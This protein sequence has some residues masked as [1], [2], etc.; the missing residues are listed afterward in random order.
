MKAFAGDAILSD[1]T[2]TILQDLG[3]VSFEGKTA[4][5]TGGAGFLGS[6]MCEVLVSQ[7]ARVICLDNLSSGLEA[8]ISHLSGNGNFEFT[9]HDIT[10]PFHV[11]RKI[12]LVLHL[13]SRASPFEFERFPLEIQS[14]KCK[15]KTGFIKY[16]IE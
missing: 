14:K 3:E 12:D 11:E 2:S 13:A 9:K 15:I 1:D 5:V 6:W 16:L 8:N 10:K 7:E 4:L